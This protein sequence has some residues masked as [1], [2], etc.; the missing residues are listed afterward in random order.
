MLAAASDGQS[1]RFQTGHKFLFAPLAVVVAEFVEAWRVVHLRQVSQFVVNHIVA[2]WL[3][4]KYQYTA[5]GY[6]TAA[7]AAP[8]CALAFAY[9]PSDGMASYAVGQFVCPRY[10]Y[11]GS[12]GSFSNILCRMVF[13]MEKVAL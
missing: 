13:R 6:V 1:G 2:Q 3:L 5:Q 11:C 10:Q 7:V 8:Q 9:G 4:V 12:F